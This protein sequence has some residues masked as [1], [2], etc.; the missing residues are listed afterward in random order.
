[1]ADWPNA[2][3]D[4]AALVADV[5]Q[6]HRDLDGL[7]P[8]PTARQ[9]D[10]LHATLDVRMRE[11][12]VGTVWNCNSIDTVMQTYFADITLGKTLA[13]AMAVLLALLSAPCVELVLSQETQNV[14]KLML[15]VVHMLMHKHSRASEFCVLVDGLVLT[16]TSAAVP[17]DVRKL[18]AVTRQRPDENSVE[19]ELAH[20]LEQA[21]LSI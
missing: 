20:R 17:T 14:N 18:T 21:D 15:T 6:F 3:I 16:L 7:D 4:I 1:M 8:V 2:C 9:R 5:R 12:G 10:Y 19:G 13:K 11:M